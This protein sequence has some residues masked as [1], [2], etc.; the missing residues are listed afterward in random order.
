MLF[1]LEA[2]RNSAH[3]FTIMSRILAQR[4]FPT[5]SDS[6]RKYLWSDHAD[7]SIALITSMCMTDNS[8]G[9]CHS[10]PFIK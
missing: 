5:R 9:F 6:K 8:H 10:I 4:Q 7:A 2:S 3:A 1:D